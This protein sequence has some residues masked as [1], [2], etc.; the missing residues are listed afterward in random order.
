MVTEAL[1][2]L[3]VTPDEPGLRLSGEVPLGAP[4]SFA[5]QRYSGLL[6]PKTDLFIVEFVE[7]EKQIAQLFY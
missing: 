4:V 7:R 3:K 6:I 5:S 1:S 2:S